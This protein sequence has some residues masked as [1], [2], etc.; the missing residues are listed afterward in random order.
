MNDY[1]TPASPNKID[2]FPN[3]L[4]INEFMADNDIT[5]V[6]SDGSSP[7]WIELFNAGYERI[8]L[9]GSS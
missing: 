8:D 9:S 7:D 5:V 6:S 3:Y 1:A 2:D 4:F